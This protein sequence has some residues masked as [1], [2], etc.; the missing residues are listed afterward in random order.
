MKY[1]LPSSCPKHTPQAVSTFHDPSHGLQRSKVTNQ[2][3]LGNQS[4]NPGVS[5]RSFTWP[6]GYESSWTNLGPGGRRSPRTDPPFR[7]PE[8]GPKI[9]EVNSPVP[10]RPIVASFVPSLSR[11]SCCGD[12]QRQIERICQRWPSQ[13]MEGARGRRRRRRTSREPEPSVLRISQSPLRGCVGTSA[14]IR[15]PISCCSAI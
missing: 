1:P 8:S 5:A 7:G 3:E 2:G 4:A 11:S 10:S 12:V 13:S 6:G 9:C 14:W 15:V